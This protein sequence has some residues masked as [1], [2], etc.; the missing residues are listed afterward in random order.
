MWV[1]LECR[2]FSLN[3]ISSLKFIDQNGLYFEIELIP[4]NL[5]TKALSKLGQQDKPQRQPTCQYSQ[6][7]RLAKG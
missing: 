5:G 6:G 1:G 4:R 3:T 7:E 2:L